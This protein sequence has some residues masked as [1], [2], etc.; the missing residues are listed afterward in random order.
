MQNRVAIV[1]GSTAGIGQEA[2]KLLAKRGCRVVITGTRET[3]IMETV[4][5]IRAEG[6]VAAGVAANIGVDADLDK[7]VAFAQE[8][9]GEVEI[10]VNNAGITRDNLFMR[11]KDE[12]WDEVMALNLTSVFKLSKRVIRAMMKGR[13]GRIVN[14]T[15]VVGF[16]GNAGQANYTAAK[17]GLVGFTKSLAQEVATRGITVN[18][19]APGFIQTAMTDKLNEKTQ[20]AIL[21][22]IPMGKM[23][24]VEDI[25][26][27]I[28]F[29]AS[30]EARYITGE[31]IHVNGGMYMG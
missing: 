13:Y 4:E 20:E 11:M 12:E 1:T 26:A 10:L 5:A 24:S 2:A 15:S 18:G 23:G 30:D 17:A 29:L 6:G 8:Q 22:Q 19:V 14:V 9:F 28:A 31:T 3:K 7:L 21:A 16:S 27:A 25:A